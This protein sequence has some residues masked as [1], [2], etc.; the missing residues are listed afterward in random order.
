MKSSA[1][2]A[3]VQASLHALPHRIYRRVNQCEK[4]Y[5]PF[6]GEGGLWR[7]HDLRCLELYYFLT[8]PDRAWPDSAWPMIREIFYESFGRAKPNKAHKVLAAWERGFLQVMV[9]QNIDD[10]HRDA[11]IPDWPALAEQCG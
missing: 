10:L 2:S 9:T 7:Q 11:G 6:R 8:N 4:R 1:P 3:N 5:P